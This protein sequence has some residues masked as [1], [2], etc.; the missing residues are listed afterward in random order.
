[1]A[2]EL[3]LPLAGAEDGSFSLTP[4]KALALNVNFDLK[5]DLIVFD[6]KVGSTP[7]NFFSGGRGV[8]QTK[9]S[10]AKSYSVAEESVT[11]T[12]G[13]VVFLYDS[14]GSIIPVS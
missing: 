11:T 3:L 7:S 12:N 10:S 13:S 1:E 6:P 4:F 14:A 2:E 9:D 8:Q 5:I